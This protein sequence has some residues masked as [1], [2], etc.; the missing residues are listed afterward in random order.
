MKDAQQHVASPSAVLD[1]LLSLRVSALC[2]RSGS[3][4]IYLLGISIP[5]TINQSGL[6]S[7]TSSVPSKISQNFAFLIIKKKNPNYSQITRFL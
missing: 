1:D 2:R 7:F 4:G 5:L 6:I 3:L